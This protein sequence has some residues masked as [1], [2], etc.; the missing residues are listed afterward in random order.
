MKFLR[1]HKEQPVAGTVISKSGAAYRVRTPSG[2]MIPATSG[3]TWPVGSGVVV[4]A[5][6]I[7]GA[8]GLRK[9]AKVYQV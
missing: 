4:L 2:R 5:G 1:E 6:E 3:A 7:I 8:S 9:S